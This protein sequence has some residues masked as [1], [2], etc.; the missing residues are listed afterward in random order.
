[1]ILKHVSPH[2]TALL[3]AHL[4]MD[5]IRRV[6]HRGEPQAVWQLTI[7]LLHEGRPHTLKQQEIQEAD[8]DMFKVKC[9]MG[10]N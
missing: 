3:I 1:M 6:S 2:L 9:T 10:I 4:S 7:L 5:N 8:R